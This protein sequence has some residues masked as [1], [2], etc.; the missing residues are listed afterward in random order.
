MYIVLSIMHNC[1]LCLYYYAG[2]TTFGFYSL[3]LLCCKSNK[4]CKKSFFPFYTQ[5]GKQWTVRF[6]DHSLF[7]CQIRLCQDRCTVYPRLNAP[8]PLQ[9]P[10]FFFQAEIDKIVWSLFADFLQNVMPPGVLKRGYQWKS[11]SFSSDA[12]LWCC[13]AN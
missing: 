9:A 7:H 4:I 13:V 10:Q 3:I 12:L 8:P 6:L 2:H 1:F 5:N 11:Q